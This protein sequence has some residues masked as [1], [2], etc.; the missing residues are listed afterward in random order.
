MGKPKLVPTFTI[1][2]RLANLHTIVMM[3]QS[4]I[5]SLAEELIILRNEIPGL[6]DKKFL[7]KQDRMEL[8]IDQSVKILNVLVETNGNVTRE[9]LNSAVG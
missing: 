4:T 7:E 5:K 2:E 9:Q 8:L 1:E 3:Q 6:V